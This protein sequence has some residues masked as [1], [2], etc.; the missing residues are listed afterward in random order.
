M[1]PKKHSIKTILPEMD[2]AAMD[3]EQA[4]Q[5]LEEEEARLL[6]SVRKTVSD[7]SDL[8]YGGLSNPNLRD[9]VLEGLQELEKTCKDKT[10]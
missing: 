6:A 1:R 9:E 3:L 4:I 5:K 7:M 8:R 2:S 10:A